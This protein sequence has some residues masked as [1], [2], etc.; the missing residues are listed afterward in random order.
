[1]TEG[2]LPDD[3]VALFREAPEDFVS[4]R[5]RLA[6]ILRE[7]GR[8]D[9]ARVVKAL[10][11]PTVVAWAL[12]QLCVRD[13]DGVRNLLDVGAEV[14]AAQQG[15]LSSKRGAAE[16]LQAASAARKGAVADL[17]AVAVAAL[18]E[19]G[20]SSDA[21]GDALTR[22]LET[23]SIEAGAGAKL[24]AGTFERPP[25]ASTGFGEMF[26]LTSI[27]GGRL[28]S[29]TPADDAT[30][31]DPSSSDAAATTGTAGSG[32]DSDPVGAP[33]SGTEPDLGALRRN[34]DAAVRRAK[35]ARQAADG[36]AHE[37]DGMRRR[38][39]VVEQKH[40]RAAATA[41]E[42]ETELAR[43]EKA[44]RSATERP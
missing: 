31:R 27:D 5:D 15:A 44:M 28:R 42:A 11:K 37:L 14:R 24:S 13:P 1:M 7:Q 8:A 17:T 19:R 40:A 30:P 2:P 32:D 34:L 16:R 38:L 33:A 10:R 9:D 23:C 35:K 12:D 3:A 36:F 21:H 6:V 26:G 43:A 39:E 41:A 25:A 4:A 18:A 20:A 22:A 29:D